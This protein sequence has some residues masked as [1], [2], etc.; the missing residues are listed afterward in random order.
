MI[1]VFLASGDKSARIRDTKLE[2]D[3]ATVWNQPQ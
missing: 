2:V 3:C 1:F